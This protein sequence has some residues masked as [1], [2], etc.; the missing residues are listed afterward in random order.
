[1]IAGFETREHV[2][3]QLAALDAERPRSA[4][5]AAQIKKQR[6]L[7]QAEADRFE[8]EEVE[9]LEREHGTRLAAA[10]TGA[11]GIRR[12]ASLLGPYKGTV[13]TRTRFPL[14]GLPSSPREGADAEDTCGLVS[15]FPDA[16][17]SEKE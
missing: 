11:A 13:V 14:R 8:A 6:K 7:F 5:H 12:R 15:A 4:E 17:K 1:M 9:R 3:A 2:L 10:K 16:V